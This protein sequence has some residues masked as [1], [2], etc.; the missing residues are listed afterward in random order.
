VS[1]VS[2]KLKEI[3]LFF[4]FSITLVTKQINDKERTAAAMEN[5]DLMKIV[6]QCIVDREY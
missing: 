3:I 6:E 4:C 1:I 5:P 2:S